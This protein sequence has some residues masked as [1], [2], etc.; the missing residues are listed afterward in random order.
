MAWSPAA[1]GPSCARAERRV[2]TLAVSAER[3]RISRD[4]H[5][6][7]GHSLTAISIKSE[8][9]GRLIDANPDAAKAQI[10]EVEE[11]ARQALADV[12]STASAIREVRVAVELAGARSVLL[13]AGI[14]AQVPAALPALTDET[15]E[16]FG[17]VVREAVT[18]VVRHSGATR[19]TISVTE[20]RVEI[21]DNGSGLGSES[22]GLRPARAGRAG[23]RG[24]RGARGGLGA[25][26]AA[27]GS[28]PCSAGP[29]PISPRR[30]APTPEVTTEP[31]EH[32][33]KAGR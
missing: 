2:S 18:N 11:I 7:L 6:I 30:P 27:P 14:E 10:A 13:A 25:R 26:A 20:D 8:L 1:S 33:G 21:V 5:D 22:G 24:G 4:L 29:S 3:E 15:S 9:A 12:R 28:S 19:C 23:G 17:F 31:A 16:L 32:V